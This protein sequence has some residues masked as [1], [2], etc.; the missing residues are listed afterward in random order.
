MKKKNKN[1]KKSEHFSLRLFPLSAAAI[2]IS[3]LR[4]ARERLLAAI[5]NIGNNIM[6]IES[7]KY[8]FEFRRGSRVSKYLRILRGRQR[9][10]EGDGE[11]RTRFVMESH[12]FVAPAVNELSWLFPA[13]RIAMTTIPRSCVAIPSR[14]AEPRVERCALGDSSVRLSAL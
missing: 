3:R 13:L 5:A 8:T 11:A 9:R 2:E 1:K 14:C 10:G 12:V 6:A 7:S 4:R